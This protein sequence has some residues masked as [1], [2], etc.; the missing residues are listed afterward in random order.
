[1]AKINLNYQT[2]IFKALRQGRFAALL[3]PL[4]VLVEVFFEIMIPKQMSTIIDVGIA[5]GDTAFIIR[6]GA[7]LAL[8]AIVALFFGVVAGAAIS[9]AGSILSQN[10]RQ[11]MFDKIMK[12]SFKN[13]DRFQHGSLVTRLTTDLTNIQFAFMMT[14]RILSR[15]PIMVTMALAMTFFI[16]PKIAFIYLIAAP[17]LFVLLIV[18]AIKAHPYFRKVFSEYDKLNN[19]V[20]ENVIG[21]R[22]V[23]SFLRE[24]NEIEKFSKVTDN[25]FDLH[26]TAEKIVILTNPVM[27]FTVYGVVI[28]ILLIGGKSIVAGSMST[29]ELTSVMIYT[30]QVLMSMM[31]VSFVFVMNMVSE[32]SRERVLEVL[33][34]KIDLDNK[35]EGELLTEVAN[36]EIVFDNVNFSYGTR[37]SEMALK[38]I[39]CKIPSGS[40]FGIIGATGSAKSTFVQLIPRLYDVVSGSVKVAGRDVRDYDLQSLRDAVAIVLQKNVLFKGTISENLRW[41]NK[42]A[43]DEALVNAC[44]IAQADN[45]IQGFKEGYEHELTSLATNLSGGQKQRICIARALLKEPKILILDDSTSAVDTKTDSMIQSSLKEYLPQMTKIII[46][47]RVSSVINA[48]QVMVLADGEINGIGTP[49]ELLANNEIFKEIYALQMSKE[50]I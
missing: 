16:Q 36:G 22:V 44:K 50:E 47:Q 14:V 38:N 28:F 2:R 5:Q 37:G 46:A 21:S 7:L 10:L 15:T 30:M 19:S 41:G 31:M 48:D 42:E 45:F 4:C 24:Q 12:F 23:K 39:S 17:I 49:E 11:D 43:S 9:Y 25:L 20:S 32:A 8:M 13:M 1:M 3:T 34:E 29:G 40:T 6:Q 26:T 18:I 33:D 27:Q 35:S